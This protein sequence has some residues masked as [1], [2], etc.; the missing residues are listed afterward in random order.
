MELFNRDTLIAYVQCMLIVSNAM[1]F[2]DFVVAYSISYKSTRLW[3]ALAD[4]VTY[5]AGRRCV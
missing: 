3:Y 2:V 1:L 5:E 4:A